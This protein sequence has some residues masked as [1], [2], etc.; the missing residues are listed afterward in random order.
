MTKKIKFI[1]RLLVLT[2][3]STFISCNDELYGIKNQHNGVDKNKISLNQF[4]NETNIN[5]VESILSV[6]TKT[7]IASKTKSQLS[8]FVIDTLAIKKIVSQNKNTTYTFRIY[9]LFKKNN[10]NEYYNLV[11]R[12]IDGNWLKTVFLLNKKITPNKEEIRFETI[13]KISLDEKVTSKNQKAA[14]VCYQYYYEIRCNGSCDG[15]C[16]GF[17]CPTGECLSL[18]VSVGSCG[19]GGGGSGTTSPINTGSPEYGGGGGSNEG[20]I[21]EFVFSPNTFANLN[22]DDPNF[23]NEWQKSNVWANLSGP[24]KAYFTATPQR[25][26]IFNQII[27]YQ[28]ENNWSN[29][30]QNFGQELLGLTFEEYNTQDANSLV[31]ISILINNNSNIIFEDDFITSLD[32]YVDLDLTTVPPDFGNLFGIKLYLNYRKIR[33]LNPEWSKGKCIWYASRDLIHLSLDAFGLIPIG[34]EIADLANGALYTIE[35]DGVNAALSFASAVPVAGWAAVGVKYAVKIKTV[36]TIGTKVKLTWK[37]L[38]DGTIY[39]GSN[40]TCRAQLRK[41]LGLAVGNLNQAHHIIPLNLQTNPIVQK[42]A[43]SADAFHL[44][45]ALNGIPL[46]TAVHSGS[47]GNYD[48]RIFQKLKL[49]EEA[50]PNA[51]PSQC[52][53]KVNEIISQIRTAIANNPNTPI[54]Q[55]NF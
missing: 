12:K 44:N 54:N 52:Y 17:A 53:N 30:S 55:L 21:Y 14:Q 27:Q 20:L 35:G 26:D 48:A 3:F 25:M 29:D 6:T 2:L 46:S 1:T 50:N 40:N 45:E 4:K 31:N 9:P 13:E 11:Y 5:Q 42:A 38:A 37:V 43:K 41:V 36:A 10:E 19:G 18:S 39:F 7:S 22:L 24:M 15:P 32:P 8:D 16:D 23:I 33:M 47:H 49:F 28:I 51:T 34:G